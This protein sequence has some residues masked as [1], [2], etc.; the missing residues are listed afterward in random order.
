[1]K[2]YHESVISAILRNFEEK[3]D[4]SSA[5]IMLHANSG[6]KPSCIKTYIHNLLP[7]VIQEF[8]A[9]IFF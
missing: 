9:G 6:Y 3:T 7:E 2:I 5:Q 1:M 4:Y 8:A